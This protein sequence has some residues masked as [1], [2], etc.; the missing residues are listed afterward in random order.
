MVDIKIG[1]AAVA[2][3]AHKTVNFL[4]VLVLVLRADETSGRC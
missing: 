3:V 4:L 2:A 1:R